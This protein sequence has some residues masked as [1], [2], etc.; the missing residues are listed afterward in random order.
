[1]TINL[2]LNQYGAHKFPIDARGTSK[3]WKHKGIFG[4]VLALVLAV[5]AFAS[6]AHFGIQ[7]GVKALL[8]Q[9]AESTGM[10]WAYH[11]EARA[12]NLGKLVE[13][14]PD[15]K[16]L[17]TPDGVEFTQMINGMLS[18]GNIY[19][20]DVI[21]PD[22][23]CE[24]SLGTYAAKQLG[25]AKK[26][27]MSHTHN[28]SEGGHGSSYGKH[29]AHGNHVAKAPSKSAM[30]HVFENTES[31]SLQKLSSNLKGRYP[32]DGTYAQKIAKNLNHEILL[33]SSDG[34][35]QPL[36]FAEVF[37]PVTA[38]GNLSYILRILVDV[39]AESARFT[40]TLYKGAGLVLLLLLGAFIY[41]ASQ[42]YA[43]SKK[44]RAGDREAHFLANH[45]VMTN[46]FSRN[47][48]QN[49][50]PKLL[51]ACAE[52]NQS[53]A[54]FLFDIDKFKQIN[55]YH[56]HEAGDTI[57][58]ALADKLKASAPDG[59]HVARLGGDEFVLI[60]AGSDDKSID[61]KTIFD[62]PSTI[63]VAID[64][65]RQVIEAGVSTG[66]VQFPRDGG[67]LE[68]LMRNA[69]LALYEAKSASG[70]RTVE[71]HAQMSIEFY[72]GLDL[73]E[74]FE[75]ALNKSQ[76]VPHYQPLV[77]METGTVQGFEALARWHHPTKGILT[78][79]VFEKMLND[80]E[81]G[82][83]VGAVMLKKIVKDMKRWKS[84]GIQFGNV[85]LNVG[86]GDLS[87]PGFA[88]NVISEIVQNDLH[89]KDLAIEVTETC[90][91]G[92]N[93]GPLIGQLQHLRRAGCWVGLDDF[94]TGYSSITQIKQLPCTA[95]KIDKSF[96]DEVVNDHADQSIIQSLLE[97]G[98]KLGF[99]LVLE[100]VE[101][102]EQVH[103]LKSLGCEIAQG[104]H[105]SRPVP[106]S[107]IPALINRLN[108]EM[109]HETPV[110]N[111]A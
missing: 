18:V 51:Q 32:L 88:L 76:I 92:P 1:M 44:K 30:K 61:P 95:V 70:R 80:H 81:I 107:D 78:P 25:Q 3:E 82:A 74:E 59:A 46:V 55:D 58:R 63:R 47:G 40:A 73:R 96:V 29:A 37:H 77:C 110:K 33:H 23:N 6:S 13:V 108:G 27:S 106:A 26:M 45:D 79:H 97:L 99:K 49:R 85:G 65:N 39:H 48:F 52:Q 60:V 10:D 66:V 57:I 28:H 38:D 104:Y 87:Q 105:Y 5:V 56:S 101:T 8:I 7:Y 54:I 21:N 34:K 16:K 75:E 19:Q 103:L 109:K 11:I 24:I 100:G 22:C 12:P 35:Y 94:G 42:Y 62:A 50:A 111:V 43:S 4:I 64:D 90:V 2:Q 31:H 71:Y 20:V 84:A 67:N 68:E 17:K 36:R 98:R 9:H 14:E 53:A 91:F 102:E 15:S 72:E 83:K 89:P 69:D 86:E 41:P 93:S